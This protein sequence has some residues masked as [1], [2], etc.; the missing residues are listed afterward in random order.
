MIWACWFWKSIRF[1]T[2][3]AE[4][5]EQ[6]LKKGGGERDGGTHDFSLM[7]WG[8]ANFNEGAGYKG[9]EIFEDKIDNSKQKE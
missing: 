3:S 2:R 5:Q 8:E 6:K 1:E 9:I 4:V 7:R